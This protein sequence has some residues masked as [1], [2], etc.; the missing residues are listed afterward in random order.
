ME[1]KASKKANDTDHAIPLCDRWI[2]SWIATAYLH[3][4]DQETREIKKITFTHLLY[5]GQLEKFTALQFLLSQSVSLMVHFP[6]HILNPAIA[7]PT[8]SG[9]IV[10]GLSR[11]SP[12]TSAW[13]VNCAKIELVGIDC[14]LT[15]YW[16]RSRLLTLTSSSILTSV[17]A[18]SLLVATV[19]AIRC[20]SAK[21][22]VR[23]S[24]SQVEGRSASGTLGLIR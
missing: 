17:C 3:S 4:W 11:N 19:T 14:R 15:S 20:L 10:P 5:P 13:C 2:P 9:W 22:S 24:P 18:D 12:G 6:G 16:S 21:S 7:T 8:R 23:T 1:Y